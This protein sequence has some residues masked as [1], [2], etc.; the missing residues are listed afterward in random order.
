MM[1]R[2]ERM[3]KENRSI[4]NIGEEQKEENKKNSRKRQ[5]LRED[6]RRRI[7]EEGNTRKRCGQ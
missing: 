6:R 7:S 3:N 5:K 2:E 4:G 1:M